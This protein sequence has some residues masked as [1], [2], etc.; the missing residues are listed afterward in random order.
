MNDDFKINVQFSEDGE[1]L[2]KIVE[3]FLIG[4]LKKK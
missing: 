3:K 1:E 4:V 2:E